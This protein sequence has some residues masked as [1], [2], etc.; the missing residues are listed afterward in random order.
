MYLQKNKKVCDDINGYNLLD[1][2]YD[3]YGEYY[4]DYPDNQNIDFLI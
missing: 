3:N 4:P 1:V 2:I